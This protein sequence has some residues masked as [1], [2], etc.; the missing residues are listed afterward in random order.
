MADATDNMKAYKPD[1]CCVDTFYNAYPSDPIKG[2]FRETVTCTK[3]KKKF[4]MEFS[5][6]GT[7]DTLE[8]TCDPNKFIRYV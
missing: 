3:C 7:I 4:V 6:Y 2:I 5:C 1:D 8:L